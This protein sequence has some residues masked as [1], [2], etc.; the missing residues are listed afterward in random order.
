M[1]N[2]L[3]VFA[4]PLAPRLKIVSKEHIVPPD[5]LGRLWAAAPDSSLVVGPVGG[6]EDSLL[7]EGTVG[8]T[9]QW[10]G[11]GRTDTTEVPS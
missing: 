7:E 1:C 4:D 5:T 2:K 9:C 8:G 3:W 11:G 6:R 10:A